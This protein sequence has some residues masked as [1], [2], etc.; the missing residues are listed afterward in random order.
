MKTHYF[1]A[2]NVWL[3]VALILVIGKK[4]VYYGQGPQRS[5]FGVGGDYT[6]EVYGLMV[7][8]CLAAGII[9]LVKSGQ[10]TNH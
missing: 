4:A 5:F 10:D 7:L 2:G 9:F 6:P 8:T 3:L 1:T